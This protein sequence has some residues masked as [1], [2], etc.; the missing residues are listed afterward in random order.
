MAVLGT[1]DSELRYPYGIQCHEAR[2]GG[3]EIIAS[4]PAGYISLPATS[5]KKSKQTKPKCKTKTNQKKILSP[6]NQTF[7]CDAKHPGQDFRLKMSKQ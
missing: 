3:G 5:K 6:Q 2:I 4:V 1:Y 7:N